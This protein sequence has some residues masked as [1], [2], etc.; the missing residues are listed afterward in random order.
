MMTMRIWALVCVLAM[1]L[2]ACGSDDSGA[3]DDSGSDVSD[4][5]GGDVVED[6][7]ADSDEPT[8][9]GLTW[10]D[11]IQPMMSAYCSGCHGGGGCSTGICWLDSYATVSANARN[12]AACDGARAACLPV[13]V[14]G[15]QMPPGGCLPGNP[16]C[17]TSD[18]FGLLEDW[19]AD[20]FP[21]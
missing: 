9:D 3:S 16:G 1:G 10:T 5:S 8:G 18:Q 19:V 21:E 17:I 15:G 4:A 12:S 7:L 11:D 2:A 6:T 20:G 13:R 14:S